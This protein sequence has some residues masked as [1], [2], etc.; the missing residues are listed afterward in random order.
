MEFLK[1]VLGDELYNQVSE[2]LKGNDKIKLANLADGGYVSKD[3]FDA[4]E[5]SK[6]DFENQL[7]ERDNQL[8]ELKKV[9]PEKLQAEITRLQGENQT[10]KA[11]YENKLKALQLDSKLESKLRDEGAVNAKA[12]KALLDSSKISLDG[13]NLIGV[14]DQLKALKE[15]EKWAFAQ[16]PAVPGAGGNPAPAPGAGEQKSTFGDAVTERIGSGE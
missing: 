6:K 2:K 3:K 4:I 11:D 7:S 16:T 9:E 8:A 1:D 13:D 14:D 15:S 12:V 5:K 10:A